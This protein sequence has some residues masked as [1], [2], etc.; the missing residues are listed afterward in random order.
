MFCARFSSLSS[1]EYPADFFRGQILLK[2]ARGLDGY[3]IPPLARSK[4]KTKVRTERQRQHEIELLSRSLA[5]SL[6]RA[7]SLTH[8]LTRSHT[9]SPSV[10]HTNTP[11]GAWLVG[12]S[13]RGDRDYG[14]LDSRP[15]HWYGLGLGYGF[16]FG[17]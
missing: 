3:V 7:R 11:T 2:S 10:A 9:L 14:S 12:I 17:V 15:C 6:V 1:Q 5:R 16:R 13:S 8:T 4:N